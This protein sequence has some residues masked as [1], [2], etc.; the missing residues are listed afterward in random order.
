MTC[1]LTFLHRTLVSLVFSTFQK[2]QS[3]TDSQ[4]T[5]FFRNP[6]QGHLN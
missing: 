1:T 6:N 4:P 2:N 3:P 5:F